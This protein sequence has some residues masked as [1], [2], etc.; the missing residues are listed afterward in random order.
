MKS[1]SLFRKLVGADAYKNVILATNRWEEVDQETGN[2]REQQ[3]TSNSR[4]WGLMRSRGC[5]TKRVLNT[6]ESAL[7]LVRHFVTDGPGLVTLEVQKELVDNKKELI[8][9]AVGQEAAGQ[10]A[11]QLRTMKK[12]LEDVKQEFK[13]ALKAKDESHAL[14]IKKERDRAAQLVKGL[15]ASF[16]NL[17]VDMEKRMGL[18]AKRQDIEIQKLLKLSRPSTRG[19]ASQTSSRGIGMSSWQ[20]LDL[21]VQE[22]EA[23]G[24]KKEI[25]PPSLSYYEVRW[26]IKQAKEVL[27]SQPTLLQLP[28]PTMVSRINIMLGII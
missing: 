13:E 20:R 3:L 12:E 6:K 28:A 17:R 1:L 4:F 8:D 11:E 10:H 21:L 16:Q 14:A 15:E 9:T 23:L 25:I 2:G 7:G 22:Y 26:I 5:Q 24:G 18:R 27:L 19:T